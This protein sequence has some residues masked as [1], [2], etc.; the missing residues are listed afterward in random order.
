MLT[1]YLE[2]TMAKARYDLVSPGRYV[3]E[4]A[5]FGLRVEGENLEATRRALREALDL[6]LLETLRSGLIPPGL[7][8]TP[9]PLRERFFALAQE[10]WR[11]LREAPAPLPRPRKAPSLEEW[12]KGLGVQV[13]RRHEEGEEERERVLNLSLIHI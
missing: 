11:L 6:H 9:D 12:I 3:G 7:E 4:L 2:E 10:M 8:A 13:V 5:E 1:R